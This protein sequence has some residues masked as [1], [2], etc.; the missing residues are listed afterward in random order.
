MQDD[1]RFVQSPNFNDRP[2]G[3]IIDSII[4]H[5][6]GK[7][8]VEDVIAHFQDP[9]PENNNPVSAH[10]V[11][12]REGQITNMVHPDKRAWHAG[13]SKFGCRAE[14]NHFSIGIELYNSGHRRGYVAYTG[15][16]IVSTVRLVQW[17]YTQYPIK[18]EWVLGHSDVAPDRKQD[19]GELFP[20]EEFE[21]RRLATRPQVLSPE[22]R[23]ALP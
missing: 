14:F 2:V 16:Q 7:A 9:K 17:L 5:Y 19:P 20:W 13:K 21:S 15:E 10:Y 4:I 1:I 6:S 23:I 11:I 12:C 8:C 18:P 3:T 22:M